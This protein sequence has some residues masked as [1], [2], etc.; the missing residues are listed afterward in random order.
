MEEIWLPIKGFEGLYEVSSFGRVRSL[1]YH[2]TG[3]T[4]ILV[5]AQ[6][7]NGYLQVAL[8]KNGKGNYYLI[9]R[10]VAEAFIPN[11]FEDSQVNHIDEDKTNNHVD[12]LEWCD[13][14]YNVNYGTAIERMKLCNGGMFKKG[15]KLSE[16]TQRKITEKITNGKCSKA[17]LQYTKTGEF[18]REFPSMQEVERKLGISNSKVC[19]VCKGKRNSAGGYVWRYK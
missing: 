14:K 16:E 3:Q 4:R 11:W 17:V 9:H 18:I 6:K 1:N 12:N 8:W 15:N 10:L 2:R 5:P 19:C 13:A 7:K